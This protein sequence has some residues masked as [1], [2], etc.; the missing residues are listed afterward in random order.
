MPRTRLRYLGQLSSMA[1]EYTDSDSATASKQNNE[2]GYPVGLKGPASAGPG[3]VTSVFQAQAITQNIKG[4]W[5]THGTFRW[6]F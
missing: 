6:R 5:L 4:A 3:H 1:S 2:G